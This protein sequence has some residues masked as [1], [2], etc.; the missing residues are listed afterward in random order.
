MSLHRALKAL[1][2]P[3]MCYLGHQTRLTPE[4]L[5]L[6]RTV[7]H[8][9]RGWFCWTQKPYPELDRTLG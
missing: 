4:L 6:R 5:Q 2:Q 1:A 7:T 8:L 9:C 3:P